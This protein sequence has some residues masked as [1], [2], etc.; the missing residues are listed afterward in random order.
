MTTK[1][2]P[3]RVESSKSTTQFDNTLA[4]S[5][6]SNVLLLTPRLPNAARHVDDIEDVDVF[7]D[8][9]EADHP[10]WAASLPEG[11]KAFARAEIAKERLSVV[12]RLRLSRGLSQADLGRLMN[13]T[14]PQVCKLESKDANPEFSTLVK[15]AAALDVAIGDLVTAL[16]ADTLEKS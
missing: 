5:G 11:R 14:Q 7:L 9:F 8:R 4:A 10:D 15:L 2:I 1:V 6:E 12:A 16:A 3:L 13:T